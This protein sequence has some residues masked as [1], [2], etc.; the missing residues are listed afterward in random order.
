M[1]F[2]LLLIATGTII[3]MFFIPWKYLLALWS[4]LSASVQDQIDKAP[5]Y[6]FEGS[7]AYI[8][9]QGTNPAHY[10]SGFMNSATRTPCDSNALFKIASIEKLYLAVAV[11]KL[12]AQ[13]K[14]ELNQTLAFYFPK[15]SDK[16]EYAD[17][18][19]IDMLVQHRSG[20]P[21]LTD[22]KNFWENPPANKQNALDLILGKS[23][24]FKPG[25]Q[26]EYS[27]TNYLLLSLLIEN[28]TGQTQFQI[29][30]KYILIPLGLKNTYSS[31]DSINMDRLMSGY[32]G[33]SKEDIKSVNYG[34]MI[35]SAK[36]VG[37][38]LR[39]LNDKSIFE[40]K[41][42]QIYAS[43][44][45]F[46][47]TGLI[48]GYQSIARYDTELDAVI[49]LFTNTTDFNGP[50]W[51]FSELMYKRIVKILKSNSKI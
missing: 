34:S 20:I 13:K 37:V 32:Y 14:I 31:I 35:A 19:T 39:A 11:T 26:Y 51:S 46:E 6:G 10:T 40:G 1:K 30:Q 16:I 4:P 25:T 48:P 2:K 15:L 43:I 5:S 18:I 44:Y 17:Q 45:V 22:T 29:I 21:N 27:N 50:N 47:H 7:I 41:E 28:I 49:I 38:F 8:D 9:I 36:D 42:A 23:A 24:N 33:N 12:V 3:S